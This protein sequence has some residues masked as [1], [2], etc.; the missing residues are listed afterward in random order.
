MYAIVEIAGQ[1]FK[2]S[3][4]LKVYVHRLTNEEGSKVSFDKVLLLDDNGSITLG[5]PA[6]EGASVEAKVLQ[7]LK[8]DKVIVFKKKRRKGYKKRNGHRQYLT[9]ILIEGISA[10]GG[11]KAA[12]ASK[13]EAAPVVEATEEAAPKKAKA[14]KAEKATEETAA[15]KKTKKTDSQE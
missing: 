9:Q 10:T 12:P 14:P 4:D 3:K 1:Q 8:G 11:K 5:A 15:P 13:K 6:I 7:H 2:V